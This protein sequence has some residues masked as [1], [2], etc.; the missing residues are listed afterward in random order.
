MPLA[1]ASQDTQHTDDRSRQERFLCSR[2]TH[3]RITLES[4]ANHTRIKTRTA[5][6]IR[7]LANSFCSDFTR[8]R[9]PKNVREK[10]RSPLAS[11]RKT[12]FNRRHRRRAAR[13]LASFENSRRYTFRRVATRFS[14][15][16][17]IRFGVMLLLIAVSADNRRVSRDKRQSPKHRS[18]P[19]IAS[20][21]TSKRAKFAG[22]VSLK[23]KNSDSR[24]PP[25][26]P[27][28][29]AAQSNSGVAARKSHV[30]TARPF[31][32]E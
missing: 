17:H 18:S 24:V 12:E 13:R 5:V 4:N 16:C 30:S 22:E 11:V 32:A 19:S 1:A 23:K 20:I 3:A 9:A 2:P 25:S 27:P 29:F 14:Y 10:N 7:R 28:P 15:L 6:D 8:A 26:T 21:A 31:F